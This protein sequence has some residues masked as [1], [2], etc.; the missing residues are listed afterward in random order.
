[1]RR[2]SLLLLVTIAPA[3]AA[4]SAS[5]PER[6][7]AG[8]IDTD[9]DEYGP[10]LSADGT[11]MIFTRRIDR[12]GREILMSSTF[13][14][15]RWSSPSQLP[16]ADSSAKEPALSPDG[17]WLFFASTREWPGK[18]PLPAAPKGGAAQSRH[19]I[20]M[21]E[22]T[23]TGWGTP[24]PVPGGVNSDAYENYP[25][26]TSNGTLYWAG[27]R[28]GGRGQNDLWRATKKGNTWGP[29][30]NIGALNTTG[31]DADPFIAPDESYLIFSSDRPG[32]AGQ[33]D[34]YISLH[35]DNRWTEPVSLGAV[36]NSSDY[37]YTPWITRDG[38]WLYFSRGWG[39][40]W[41]I[42]TSEV[43]ALAGIR[44]K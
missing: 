23:K 39:E 35:T 11:S 22:R 26:I 31:T 2:A 12:R 6:V 16:F 28:D 18:A 19:D 13:A 32:G 42:R 43:P 17:R 25:S 36:I 15:G 34:L 30:E 14:G 37:E 8:V 27:Y 24:L 5:G 38:Q 41:R 10:T 9:A 1:M 4:Q 44:S 29:A 3:L 21:V 40:I 33:G 20:W 7:A